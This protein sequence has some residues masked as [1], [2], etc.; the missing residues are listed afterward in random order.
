M[1]IID[2]VLELLIQGKQI[3]YDLLLH[4][5]APLLGYC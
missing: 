1:L 2:L 5:G 4:S 3:L